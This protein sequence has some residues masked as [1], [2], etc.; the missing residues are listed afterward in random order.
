MENLENFSTETNQKTAYSIKI[1]NFEG[2][3]DLL[4]YL[5]KKNEI[6]IYD[7]PIAQIT[8]QYLE[9]IELMEV[10]DLD[11]A[12][13]FIV[14]AATLMRIK[15]QLLLPRPK[16]EEEFDPRQELV[17]A[18]LE[19]KKFKE[20]AGILETREKQEMLYYPCSIYY[21][22]DRE[23][24]KVE[25][26]K[27]NLY[28]LLAVFKQVLEKIPP[29]TYHE[30]NYQDITVE[31]RIEYVLNFLDQQK[32]VLLEELFKDNPIRLVAIVTFLA[33]LELVRTKKILVKQKRLFDPIWV[34]KI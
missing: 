28:D 12:G 6:D 7:I 29:E 15:A 20:V 10:L 21:G 5:I 14:M 26:T 1:E 11:L 9:Y 17:A 19:Y 4:L 24:V 22:Q 33:I 2:P 27:V 13:E 31:E 32:K 25:L 3:L 23:K 30:V 34:E 16:D 8:K 18:L